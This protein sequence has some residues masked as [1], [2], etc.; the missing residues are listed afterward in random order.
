MA[1]RLCSLR[2]PFGDRVCPRDTE[3]SLGSEEEIQKAGAP[4][5]TSAFRGILVPSKRPNDRM[6]RSLRLQSLSDRLPGD[7]GHGPLDGR[8]ACAIGIAADQVPIVL[9]PLLA[10]R[11]ASA[12]A[13]KPPFDCLIT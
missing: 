10:R 1:N 3:S 12:V 4:R 5:G 7:D 8:A 11:E 2:G 6:R 9:L 13:M